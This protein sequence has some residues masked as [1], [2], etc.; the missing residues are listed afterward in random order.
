MPLTDESK[1]IEYFRPKTPPIQVRRRDRGQIPWKGRPHRVGGGRDGA[2]NGLGFLHTG[3]SQEPVWRFMPPLMRENYKLY[4]SS[5]RTGVLFSRDAGNTIC[6]YPPP[7]GLPPTRRLPPQAGG[8]PPIDLRV[9]QLSRNTRRN[10]SFPRVPPRFIEEPLI[11]LWSQL[12]KS[13]PGSP[14]TAQSQ[15]QLEAPNSAQEFPVG[16]EIL[17]S[18]G[19]SARKMALLSI[20]SRE[21]RQQPQQPVPFTANATAGKPDLGPNLWNT[22]SP[23]LSSVPLSSASPTGLSP[24]PLGSYNSSPLAR[25]RERFGPSKYTSSMRRQYGNV[26]ARPF[27]FAGQ[28]GRG[29]PQNGQLLSG[30]SPITPRY[31][32]GQSTH[33]SLYGSSSADAQFDP[34]AKHPPLSGGLPELSTHDLLARSLSPPTKTPS[35][36]DE[37]SAHKLLAKSLSTGV[38][39]SPRL[40]HASPLNEQSEPSAHILFAESPST[41]TQFSPAI[42]DLSPPNEQPGNSAHNLL[43]KSLSTGVQFS[44]PIKNPPSEDKFRLPTD[45]Y[46]YMNDSG[47]RQLESPSPA[48]FQDQSGNAHLLVPGAINSPTQSIFPPIAASDYRQMGSTGAE[49]D[50]WNRI[51]I[52]KPLY[53]I[54]MPEKMT[55]P[56][57]QP[58]QTP[59]Q[60]LAPT[61]LPYGSNTHQAANRMGP[62]AANPGYYPQPQRPNT[63]HGPRDFPGPSISNGDRQFFPQP[64]RRGFG[65]PGPRH[66][67]TR[68]Q[69]RGRQ[70]HSIQQD[71]V[72]DKNGNFIVDQSSEEPQFRVEER[73]RMHAE[74]DIVQAYREHQAQV[75]SQL[76]MAHTLMSVVPPNA[77]IR[78]MKARNLVALAEFAADQGGL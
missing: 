42:R 33:T 35:L 45:Q 74:H 9:Y 12:Q 13:I 6:T 65:Y 5:D 58:P 71:Y 67:G 10:R 39:F 23:P 49:A 36:T 7:P 24:P 17:Q 53:S 48:T 14:A 21:K 29:L 64:P 15:M 37:L 28:L 55:S 68:A 43:V 4:F 18:P 52:D 3:Q 69:V 51:F 57:S 78:L 63:S 75:Q 72:R 62:P 20:L 8:R 32:D 61:F 66:G 34:T 40:R 19:V 60:V 30:L 2:Y 1:E 26:G 31:Y 41:S 22:E 47:S 73:L 38:Q 70:Q 25:R 59:G 46:G 76:A 27:P 77:P 50:S 54:N 44:P 16:Q 11:P 56:L